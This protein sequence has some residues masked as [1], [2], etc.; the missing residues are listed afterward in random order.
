MIFKPG[1]LVPA[2]ES[3]PGCVSM[4]P[5]FPTL[6]SRNGIRA[7]AAR[8]TL[9]ARVVSNQNGKRGLGEMEG[10][11]VDPHKNTYRLTVERK[12]YVHRRPS[13]WLLPN[14]RHRVTFRGE[15]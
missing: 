10:N 3:G 13:P 6:P 11:L 8:E 14:H 12:G 15:P 2:S 4:L 7:F 9:A 1:K 5:N